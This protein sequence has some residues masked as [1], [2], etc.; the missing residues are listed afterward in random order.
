[1]GPQRPI[2]QRA[3]TDGPAD[4][5]EAAGESEEGLN[6]PGGDDPAA[7]ASLLDL[8]TRVTQAPSLLRERL[9]MRA[10]FGSPKLARAKVDPAA[11]PAASDVR[12]VRK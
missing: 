6:A 12:L 2:E 1:Y 7:D 5:P 10:R 11:L 3:P 4:E 8:D 9:P